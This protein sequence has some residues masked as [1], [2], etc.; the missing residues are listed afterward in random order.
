MCN[1]LFFIHTTYHYCVRSCLELLE[2]SCYECG[3]FNRVKDTFKPTIIETLT[4]AIDAFSKFPPVAEAPRSTTE[5]VDDD[6]H[7]NS[8]VSSFVESLPDSLVMSE[9]I[10]GQFSSPT[11]KSPLKDSKSSSPSPLETERSY[12]VPSQQLTELEKSSTSEIHKQNSFKVVGRSSNKRKLIDFNQEC[13][14]INDALECTVEDQGCSPTQSQVI[15][16]FAKHS[17]ICSD[18]APEY[19]PV[20]NNNYSSNINNELRAFKSP[21]P[22]LSVDSAISNLPISQPITMNLSGP[23]PPITQAGSWIGA[24]DEVSFCN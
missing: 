3:S 13:T 20:T 10:M 6:Y 9:Y 24:Q 14:F 12:D 15:D 21:L 2:G 5:D 1:F 4:R 16:T 22:S 23:L 19:H 11:G 18:G 17:E 7:E 8:S